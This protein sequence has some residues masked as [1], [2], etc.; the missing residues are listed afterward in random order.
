MNQYNN[1]G[2]NPLYLNYDLSKNYLCGVQVKSLRESCKMRAVVNSFK[3]LEA[4]QE[5]RRMFI[6]KGQ[7]DTSNLFTI[8]KKDLRIEILP[9][10]VKEEVSLVIQQVYDEIKRFLTMINL[11]SDRPLFAGNFAFNWQGGINPRETVLRALDRN[12]F[13]AREQF[14][15]SCKYLFDQDIILRYF[16]KLIPHNIELYFNGYLNASK[17]HTFLIFYWL[18]KFSTEYFEDHEA[19]TENRVNI[20]FMSEIFFDSQYKLIPCTE[21]AIKYLFGIFKVIL[22]YRDFVDHLIREPETPR[23]NIL[24]YLLF[25]LRDEKIFTRYAYEI[26]TRLIENPRWHAIFIKYFTLLRNHVEA[27]KYLSLV[28]NV[29]MEIRIMLKLGLRKYFTL[30]DEFVRLIPIRENNFMKNMNEKDYAEKVFHLFTYEDIKLINLF[31]S[32]DIGENGNI[33]DAFYELATTYFDM[34][35]EVYHQCSNNN[36]SFLKKIIK[37]EDKVSHLLPRLRESTSPDP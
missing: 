17:S 16:N 9:C 23:I 32:T 1:T 21:L 31:I 13:S 24:M 7:K 35:A 19:Y 11:E 20:H 36:E 29:L 28:F 25:N 34:F 4:V 5:M 8:V 10:C 14:E 22:S 26:L 6:D 30:W 2:T 3:C 12:I 18:F 37:S 27:S 33:G 15:F